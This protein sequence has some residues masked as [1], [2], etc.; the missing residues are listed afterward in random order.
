MA[1]TSG[2]IFAGTTAGVPVSSAGM[3]LGNLFDIVLHIIVTSLDPGA[4]LHVEYEDG[5]DGSHWTTARQLMPDISATG[6]YR[7]D[8]GTVGRWG[9][10]TITPAGGDG[11]LS[12]Y[13]E[14]NNK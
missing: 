11:T 4:T 7:L 12:I 5:P 3:K 8:V 6:V 2:F 13:Q 10:V 9:R 14:A 1:D